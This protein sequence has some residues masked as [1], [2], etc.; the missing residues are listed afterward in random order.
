MVTPVRAWACRERANAV[1]MMLKWASIAYRVLAN[2]GLAR[3][4]V[5]LIRKDRSTCHR[6]W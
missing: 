4:S 2:S 1:N 5:L 6:A 3:R